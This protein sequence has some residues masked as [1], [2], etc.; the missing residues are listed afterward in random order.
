MLS[1]YTAEQKKL[2]PIVWKI[3]V[4]LEYCWLF[5]KSQCFKTV[6]SVTINDSLAC[7]EHRFPTLIRQYDISLT[8]YL[9][10]QLININLVSRHKAGKHW[11]VSTGIVQDQGCKLGLWRRWHKKWHKT[12]QQRTLISERINT[13]GIFTHPIHFTGSSITFSV[14]HSHCG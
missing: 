13:L 7:L 1:Q 5:N 12:L 8:P 4:I 14:L 10:N 2:E 6:P 11:N 3:Q 9:T